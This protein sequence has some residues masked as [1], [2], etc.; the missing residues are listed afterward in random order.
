MNNHIEL[1]LMESELESIQHRYQL[2]SDRSSQAP[3]IPPSTRS[4]N[5]VSFSG[6]DTMGRRNNPGKQ[7]PVFNTK[8]LSDEELERIIRTGQIPARFMPQK[9]VPVAEDLKKTNS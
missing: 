9:P 6:E 8:E 1:S 7:A 5:H 3:L 2:S 4:N